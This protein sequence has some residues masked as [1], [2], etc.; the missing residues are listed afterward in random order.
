MANTQIRFELAAW[1]NGAIP[2]EHLEECIN[3]ALA[4]AI[5]AIE[6]ART[7]LGR[8]ETCVMGD[9][10]R[11]PIRAV[12]EVREWTLAHPGWTTAEY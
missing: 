4:N 2:A 9:D 11:A 3:A 1:D 5:E 6:W 12:E 7:L 8:V 10:L